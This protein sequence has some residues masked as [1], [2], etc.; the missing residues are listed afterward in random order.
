MENQKDELKLS[1]LGLGCSR[2]SKSTSAADRTDAIA[3]IHA[4]LDAGVT[5]LDTADFYAA[6]HNEMLIGEALKGCKRAEAFLSVKFG[7]LMAPNGAMYGLDVR[8]LTVKNYLAHSL[9]RLN[10]DYIDLYQPGRIDM[11]IPVEETIGAIAEL[12]KA[13]YVKHIGI[14]EVGADDLRKAHAV[15]PI[16]L[17]ESRYSLFDRHIEREILPTARELGIGIVA[18]S[19]LAHGLLGGTWSKDKEDVNN[20]RYPLFFP[21]NIDKNLALVEALQKIAAE[22]Q[23]TLPQLAIAWMLAKGTD[24]LPLI[25]ARR[26]TQLQDSIKS[27]EVNL[28]ENDMK[29]I[30]EAIPESEIAGGN[31]PGLK[32]KNGIVV[33]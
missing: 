1:R 14:T 15:H 11:A 30:E 21:E 22:K 29:R 12:V 20:A 33:R 23:I 6:G 18:F 9:K 2:M 7:A 4:A 13:G 17:I 8:P 25:G 3:T 16:S 28:S 26:P 10:V 31:F 5:F 19:A 24:I 32:F 27:L